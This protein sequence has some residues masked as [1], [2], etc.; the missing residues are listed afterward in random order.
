MSGRLSEILH[1]LK[2]PRLFVVGDL[3]LDKFVW[4]TVQRVSPEAPVQ[5]L[6]VVREE[7]RLGGSANV[8]R[9]LATLGARAS[10]AGV[11]GRDAGGDQLVRLLRAQG[12]GAQGVVRDASKPTSVKTRMIAHNQQMLRVDSEKVEPISGAIEKALS[13]VCAKA[14]HACDAAVVSDYNKGTLTRGVCENLIRAF[15]KAGRPVLV[16]LKSRD[17]R[18]YL[19]ATGASLN[20]GELATISGED[21]VEKGARKIIKALRL[22]F[23]VLTLGERGMQVFDAG[24]RSFRLPAMAREVY[25]VTG[26]GDT[27]LSAFALGH[28]SGLSLEECA[29]LSN[30]AA[31]IVVGKVGTE[32]V[33]RTELAAGDGDGPSKIVDVRELGKRLESERRK[34]KKIVFTNGCF[35]LLHVG[36]VSLLR[37]AR[38]KGDVVVVGLNSDAS[39]RRLKGDPRPVLR[40]GERARI[41][42]A[43]EDVDYVVL[44]DEDTPERLIRDVEPDVLVK[45]EDYADKPVVGRDVVERRGGRVELAPFVKGIS[46]TDIVDRILNHLS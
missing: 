33:T 19:D 14:A 39:V 36:H 20:R 30:A 26:A 43:L 22:E 40:E 9:N 17:Y 29:V 15:R 7:Y 5:I 37:F 27:A 38:S 6:N 3:I 21:D 12:I 45:G 34:G 11:A 10:C 18:K 32:T 16:G 41:L 24:G 2:A 13:D 42:A 25:D 44:F 28:A 4:G 1:R 8:A 23:L 46:T 31:G 35:D